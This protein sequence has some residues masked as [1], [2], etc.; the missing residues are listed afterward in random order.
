MNDKSDLKAQ[1]ERAKKICK[2]ESDKLYLEYDVDFSFDHFDGGLRILF[3][4]ESNTS[5]N[6]V[7]YEILEDLDNDIKTKVNKK[8]NIGIIYEEVGLYETIDQQT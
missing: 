8:W 1:I 5:N 4:R 3:V 6:P 7:T 2:N